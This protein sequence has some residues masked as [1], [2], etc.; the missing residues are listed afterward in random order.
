M[1]N[2]NSH[3]SNG[4]TP[5]ILKDYTESVSGSEAQFVEK[6]V[7]TLWRIHSGITLYV[8]RQL[9]LRNRSIPILLPWRDFF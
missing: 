5:V 8:V 9:P 1:L 7:F 6:P 3:H 4:N 2:G